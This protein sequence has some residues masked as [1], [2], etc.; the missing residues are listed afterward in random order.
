VSTSARAPL[1]ATVAAVAF[2]T[3]TLTAGLAAVPLDRLTHQVG[4]GGMVTDWLTTAAAL[5]P[6][7]VVG[8]LLAVRRP[9]NLIGWLLLA[10]LFLSAA[11]WSDYAI[12]DY[13]M[14]HGTL[15]LGWLVVLLLNSWPIWLMVLPSGG[16]PPSDAS[17]SNGS[18]AARSSS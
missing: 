18:T 17:S 12:L 5:V 11:P 9:R 14:H 15:P 13:R 7:V 2:G 1:A 8:I 16:R 10:F 4:P 6:G 3:L